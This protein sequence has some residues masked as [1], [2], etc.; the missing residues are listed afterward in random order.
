MWSSGATLDGAV[1]IN[2][3]ETALPYFTGGRPGFCMRTKEK[4]LKA[5]MVEKSSL[6]LRRSNCTLISAVAADPGVQKVLPQVLLPNMT[7]QKKHGRLEH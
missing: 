7:R 5:H 3:D 4:Q 1:W 6:N 2:I